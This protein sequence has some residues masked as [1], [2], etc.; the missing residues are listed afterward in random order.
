MACKGDSPDGAHCSCYSDCPCCYCG[1]E[2]IA[3]VP[4]IEYMST[5]ALSPKIKR[6]RELANRLHGQQKYGEFPYVVHL[7]DVANVARRFGFGGDVVVAA[8]LL[9]DILEDTLMTYSQLLQEFG[10][11]IA[12][13]VLAVTKDQSLPT[14]KEKNREVNARTAKSFIAIVIKLCDRIANC[15]S[16]EKNNMYKKE[17]TEFKHTLM[18][19]NLPGAFVLEPLWDHLDDLLGLKKEQRFTYSIR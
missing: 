15:E 10:P 6:A 16:G 11:D 4:K 14:R 12:D 17:H 1:K 8:C 3:P 2:Y 18:S 13:A 9:H 19:E 7:W 5:K